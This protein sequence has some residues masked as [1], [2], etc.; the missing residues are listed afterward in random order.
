M[1]LLD[2]A[3][4]P[5]ASTLV[6]VLQALLDAQLPSPVTRTGLR[7]AHPALPCDQ[8]VVWGRTASA[9][10]AERVVYLHSPELPRLPLSAIEPHV[11]PLTPRWREPDLPARVLASAKVAEYKALWRLSRKVLGRTVGVAFGG[12]AALGIAH[13]GVLEVF[14]DNDLPIDAV[15]GSSFGAL[16]A[17]GVAA[18]TSARD[19]EAQLGR[20]LRPATLV[21]RLDVRLRPWSLLEGA[22]FAEMV[23]PLVHGHERFEDLEVPVVFVAADR[24]TGEPVLITDGLVRHGYLA[25]CAVPWLLPAYTWRGRS[26][27]DGGV[28]D[29]LP[30]DV[31]RAMGADRVVAVNVVPALQ[32][33]VQN[34]LA[35]G[36]A[37]W[38]Q[39]R[40]GAGNGLR[41]RARAMRDG[42]R[43]YHRGLQRFQAPVADVALH[44]RLD[45]FAWWDLHHAETLIARGREVAQVHLDLLRALSRP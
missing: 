40:P 37:T 11:V 21:T 36:F 34:F 25:S 7:L 28:A 22:G 6:E 35:Q 4:G 16:V 23:R 17:A 31:V 45:E 39:L 32:A 10:P 33:G 15:A 5:W 13:L 9:D 2:V 12:G 14:E 43:S 8:R 1:P 29:P 30:V 42:W 18:G 27:L 20:E 38:S 19:M 24:D 44:P 3:E 26:L 41:G